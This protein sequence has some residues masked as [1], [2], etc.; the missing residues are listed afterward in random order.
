HRGGLEVPGAGDLLALA[1]VSGDRAVHAPQLGRDV[2]VRLVEDDERLLA[3]ILGCGRS[4]RRR[5]LATLREEDAGDPRVVLPVHRLRQRAFGEVVVDD[6]V[7]LAG[8]VFLG[9]HRPQEGRPHR[10]T[11]R[12]TWRVDVLE[13]ETPRVLVDLAALGDPG[14]P[15]RAETL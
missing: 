6:V 12:L 3:A 13:P 8:L 1:Q 15:A 4:C 11:H 14:E 5:D 2:E 9:R 7:D 10:T